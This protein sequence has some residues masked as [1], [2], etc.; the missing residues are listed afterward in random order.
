MAKLQEK[1]DNTLQ[2][3]FGFVPKRVKSRYEITDPT[4]IAPP[5]GFKRSPSLA[6]QI[7]EMVRSERLAAEVAAAGAETFEEADDFEVPDDPM[8]PITPYEAD[9]DVPV[10]ELRR[11]QREDLEKL[12]AGGSP[13]IDSSDAPTRRPPREERKPR[14]DA[15]AALDPTAG[16]GEA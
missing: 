14:E 12:A 5:V 10:A 13:D 15:A 8:D 2:K 1:V 6:E 3:L 4:P 11:R 16:E 7:R 9:F